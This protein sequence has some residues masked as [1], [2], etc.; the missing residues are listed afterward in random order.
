MTPGMVLIALV[1]VL[2]CGF[3]GQAIGKSKGY[4]GVGFAIGLLMGIL[5]VVIVALMPETEA[6]KAA[7][8]GGNTRHKWPWRRGSTRSRPRRPGELGTRSRPSMDRGSRI[9]IGS[10]RTPDRRV[11]T[12]DCPPQAR[13]GP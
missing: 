1:V 4:P 6:A 10:L 13:P 12:Q 7:R 8:R 5:G 11:L 3:A 9:R 2:A